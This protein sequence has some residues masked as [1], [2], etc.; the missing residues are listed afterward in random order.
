MASVIWVNGGMCAKKEKGL[1]LGR[2]DVRFS[3]VLVTGWLREL[4]VF[5]VGVGDSMIGLIFK[6]QYQID[7]ITMVLEQLTHGLDFMEECYVQEE[8]RPFNR[9]GQKAVRG[10]GL[11]ESDGDDFEEEE[12]EE[13]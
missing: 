9:R 2:G 8:Y 1:P 12:E 11:D 7:Q 3:L 5:L 10:E 6:L 13:N 4:I